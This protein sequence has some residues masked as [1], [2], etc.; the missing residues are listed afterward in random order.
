[1]RTFGESAPYK[2]VLKKFGFT[3]D[4]VATAAKRQMALVQEGEK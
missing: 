1:M 2:D 3:A 4:A